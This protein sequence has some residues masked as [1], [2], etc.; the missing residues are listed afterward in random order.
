MSK[1]KC[2]V[3]AYGL[4]IESDL[5]LPELLTVVLDKEVDVRV[6]YG[7]VPQH[8]SLPSNGNPWYEIAKGEF[9]LRVDGVAKY[10]VQDGETITIESELHASEKDIRT[11]LYNT[12]FSQLLF[13][14]SLLVLHGFA[15]IIEGD[16][17][18]FVGKSGSGKTSIALQLNQYGHKILA[19][20]LCAIKINS[21]KRNILPGIPQLHVWEDTLIKACEDVSQYETVR[22]GIQKYAID[23][24]ED[25]HLRE[26]SVSTIVVLS[27]HNKDNLQWKSVQGAEKYNSIMKKLYNIDMCEYG[28]MKGITFMNC[29]AL[30]N[31]VRVYELG[32][33]HRVHPPSTLV[34]FVCK[35]LKKHE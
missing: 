1:V 32:F 13:Q 29:T 17:V 9:L 14:R 35:E 7:K 23:L 34:D 30:A 3:T 2:L 26:V 21:N 31:G 11:F 8:L 15:S 27:N 24:K 22:E 5:K 18:I 6:R 16:G 19:D 28:E 25:F 4:T 20:E 33:N 10:Y 12:V